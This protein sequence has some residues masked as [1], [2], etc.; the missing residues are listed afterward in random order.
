MHS[1]S[2][3]AVAKCLAYSLTEQK[4][5]ETWVDGKPIYRLVVQGAIGITSSWVE[6]GDMS[7]YNVDKMI[8]EHGII[9]TN[10]GYWVDI[11]NYASGI[12]YNLPSTG[13]VS[14]NVAWAG[15]YS[16]YFKYTKTTD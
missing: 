1:V 3:N 7:A 11:G 10:S 6:I 15:N 16:L 5:G 13:K 8:E 4:T 9:A 14:L 2:S 12:H